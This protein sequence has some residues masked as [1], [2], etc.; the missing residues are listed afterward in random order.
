MYAST[1]VRHTHSSFSLRARSVSKVCFCNCTALTVFD[2]QTVVWCGSSMCQKVLNKQWLTRGKAISNYK[3]TVWSEAQVKASFFSRKWHCALCC[4]PIMWFTQVRQA[5][6]LR[7]N[8][9]L[10]TVGLSWPVKT[11]IFR[12]AN[13][14]CPVQPQFSAAGHSAPP[15]K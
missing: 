14:S 15:L 12:D 8:V 3:F 6:Y 9:A 10:S 7:T 4:S 11:S 5:D 2:R 1:E 13:G